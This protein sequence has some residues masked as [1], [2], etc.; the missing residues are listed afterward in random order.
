MMKVVIAHYGKGSG[1]GTEQNRQAVEEWKNEHEGYY[2]QPHGF[3][4][5]QSFGKI[6]L[7]SGAISRMDAAEF[8]IEHVVGNCEEALGRITRLDVLRAVADKNIPLGGWKTSNGNLTIVCDYFEYREGRRHGL[9]QA[10]PTHD[11]DTFFYIESMA[12][13]ESPDAMDVSVGLTPAT[14]TV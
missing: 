10:Q 12:K 2:G 3:S 11:R 6:E 8:L 4:Q 5:T 7:R 9:R 1:L 13:D 14:E